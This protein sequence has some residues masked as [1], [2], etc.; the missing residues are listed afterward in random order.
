MLCPLLIQAMLEAVREVK[1]QQRSRSGP[2]GLDFPCSRARWRHRRLFTALTLGDPKPAAACVRGCD[3]RFVGG[4]PRIHVKSHRLCN[5]AS[6]GAP[7]GLAASPRRRLTGQPDAHMNKCNNT[8]A[9]PSS[10]LKRARNTRRGDGGDQGTLFRHRSILE[11]I[12]RPASNGPFPRL[13][14]STVLVGGV[15][16]PG[17]Q[18]NPD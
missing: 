8:R 5:P 3:E 14:S 6:G 10:F 4:H 18:R 13:A 2:L 11:G 12:W 1:G 15:P 17:S 9:L 16:V 7:R